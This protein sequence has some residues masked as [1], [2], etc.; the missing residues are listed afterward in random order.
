MGDQASSRSRSS[1]AAFERFDEAAL[2]DL[3]ANRWGVTQRDTPCAA[4]RRV[5]CTASTAVSNT[6]GHARSSRWASRSAA[7]NCD[8]GDV[9]AG[10]QPHVHNL[11]R[12]NESGKILPCMPSLQWWDYTAG[13]AGLPTTG[14]SPG[15]DRR[16][17]INDR[18][19]TSP[20]GGPH[21]VRTDQIDID[22][23]LAPRKSRRIGTASCT[24]KAGGICTRSVRCAG[25]PSLRS[26]PVH[27]P[28][29]RTTSPPPAA[30]C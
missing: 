1:S 21:T 13:S 2:A 15:R 24:A 10:R 5:T 4:Y 23:V 18:T 19:S 3:L 11:I 30:E 7:Q 16:F 20:N 28:G 22:F 25:A 29:D 9:A 26:H 27:I 12:F 14:Q 17:R 8:T 6:Q